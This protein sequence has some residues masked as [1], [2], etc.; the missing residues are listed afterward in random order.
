MKLV[1]AI[2]EPS[3]PGPYPAII[4]CHGWGANALDL[5]GLAPHLAGGIFLTVCPQGA[6][7]VPLGPT[8]GHGWFPLRPG[9][10]PDDAAVASAVA[11]ANGF[12][13]EACARYP[14]DPRRL[15]VLGFSQGGIIA[16]G[17]ALSR[18]GKF[19]AVVGVSTWFPDG[20]MQ[21]VSA[22][23][24]LTR[25]PVLIQHGRNDNLIEIGRARDSVERLRST[26]VDLRYRE[27]DCGHEITAPGLRDISEFLTEKV[28]S[29]VVTEREQAGHASA[30]DGIA[31]TLPALIRAEMLGVRSREAGFDWR[32]IHQVI[33]KIRE[34][35][36]EVEAAVAA[37][38][39]AA[40]AQE[41]G[42][43]MLALANAPRFI[44]HEAEPTLLAA[45]LKFER[46]FKH[47]E[48]SARE[49]SLELKD[50]DDAQLDALW[51]A[52]KSALDKA[53]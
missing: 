3:G 50:L 16:L 45:C 51:A 11:A 37:G 44:G 18:P 31:R 20:L 21:L 22:G 2:Y 43:A 15:V 53:P 42:D 34:E 9:S 7:T 48:R 39:S 14:I 24:D 23:A 4:A 27:Y 12:V 26:R 38:H 32:N 17:V 46:R 29:P 8:N 30:L 5:L 13:D 35:L 47:V 28:L 36:E 25:L 41:L 49:R 52:A 6:L 10:P 1:H 40:A 19:A 33:A